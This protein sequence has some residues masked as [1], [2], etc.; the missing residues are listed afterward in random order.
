MLLGVSCKIVDIKIL[1]D[2]DFISLY[3]CFR[4]ASSFKRQKIKAI[5]NLYFS[6]EKYAWLVIRS[7][8]MTI[9]PNGRIICLKSNKEYLFNKTFSFLAAWMRILKAL[10]FKRTSLN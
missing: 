1:S 8:R 3:F 4:K 10:Y 6:F 9:C 5:L 7:K 2:S